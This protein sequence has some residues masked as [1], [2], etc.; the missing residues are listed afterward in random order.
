MLRILSRKFPAQ[1]EVEEIPPPTPAEGLNLSDT[2][3]TTGF[4][5]GIAWDEMYHILCMDD[6]VQD[7]DALDGYKNNPRGSFIVDQIRSF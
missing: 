4:K 7:D 3:S 1:K 2:R 6:Y 5:R